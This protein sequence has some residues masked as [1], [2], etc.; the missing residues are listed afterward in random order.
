MRHTE[1]AIAKPFEGAPKINLA[2]VYGASPKKDIILRIP[3]TGQRPITY[4]AVGLP[5]GITLENGIITG[6]IANEGNYTVTLTAEN[7]LGKA[8]KQLTFEIKQDTV[9]LTPKC[10]RFLHQAILQFSANTA[11]VSYNVIQFQHYLES[12]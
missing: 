9:L 12:V 8:E 11:W 1:I 2:D 4:G 3:V 6:Q 7:E 10:V 5:D